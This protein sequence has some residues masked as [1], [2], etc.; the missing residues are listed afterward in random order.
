MDISV[1]LLKSSLK[2]VTVMILSFS[3]S[4]CLVVEGEILSLSLSSSFK[5]VIWSIVNSSV[6]LSV[7]TCSNLIFDNKSFVKTVSILANSSATL[8]LKVFKFFKVNAGID[9]SF[10][11]LLKSFLEAGESF[12]VGYK[13]QAT[14]D[15]GIEA[16]A[17]YTKKI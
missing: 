14:I 16:S 6:L 7:F 12:L 17:D 5:L 9:M 3:N 8:L 11:N 15:V 1:N 13:L 4:F 10:N 2:N